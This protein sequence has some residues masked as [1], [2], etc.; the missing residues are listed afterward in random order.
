MRKKINLFIMFVCVFFMAISLTACGSEV[1]PEDYTIEKEVKLSKEVTLE[2]AKK[3]VEIVEENDNIKYITMEFSMKGDYLDQSTTL[4]ADYSN[5]KINAIIDVKV[6]SV[7]VSSY[8]KDSYLYLNLGVA[9]IKVQIP[10]DE[11]YDY[12]DMTEL[13]LTEAINT[14][15]FDS[16][17]LKVGYD[18]SKSL[19]IDYNK[20][21]IKYRLVTH[22]NKPVYYY[23]IFNNETIECKF[24]MT[25]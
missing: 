22:N 18:S 3:E 9:K 4:K 2:E 17:Y 23:Y 1:N 14:I 13:D 12:E 20:D 16:E 10:S 19:I 8:I 7:T 11:N 24:I 6:G 21:N 25:K 5:K 15:N